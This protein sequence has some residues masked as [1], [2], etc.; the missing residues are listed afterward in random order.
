MRLKAQLKPR[1]N[2]DGHPLEMVIAL[3]RRWRVRRSGQL[4]QFQNAYSVRP[5]AAT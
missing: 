4:L 2:L 3:P 1:I 5:G